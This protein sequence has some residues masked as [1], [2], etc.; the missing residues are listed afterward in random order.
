MKILW[1]FIVL[2]NSSLSI[3]IY[4][5][6]KWTGRYH[7]KENKKRKKRKKRAAKQCKGLNKPN[8]CSFHCGYSALA[9]FIYRKEANNKVFL[10]FWGFKE[11]LH[12]TS[13]EKKMSGKFTS[14]GSLAVELRDFPMK[15]LYVS[16]TACF[17]KS[18][19]FNFQVKYPVVLIR[20]N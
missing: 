4:I 14:V 15:R 16:I 5:Y 19:L 12:H 11:S 8:D 7:P 1:Q 3:Y 13:M 20:E 17:S 6:I 2:T 18:S 9:L 10:V